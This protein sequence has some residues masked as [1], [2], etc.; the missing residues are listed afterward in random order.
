MI[1]KGQKLANYFRLM[2]YPDELQHANLY[3]ISDEEFDTITNM[4]MSHIIDY[5]KISKDYK[6]WKLIK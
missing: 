6:E 5:M 4:D 2:G 1:R 3:Y